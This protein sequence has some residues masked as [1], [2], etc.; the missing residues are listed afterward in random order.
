MT[1]SYPCMASDQVR[2]LVGESDGSGNSLRGYIA[3]LPGGRL[4]TGSVRYGVCVL[5]DRAYLK[6]LAPPDAKIVPVTLSVEGTHEEL[7]SLDQGLG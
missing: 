6:R 3:I 7:A 4:F 2:K 5:R 1:G